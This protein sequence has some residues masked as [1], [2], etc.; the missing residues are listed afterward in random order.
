MRTLL[1]LLAL[2][3]AAPAFAGDSYAAI[4]YDTT[5][6]A[7]TAQDTGK[8]DTRRFDC[9][10]IYL[11]TSGNTTAAV[12]HEIYDASGTALAIDT[13]TLV[14]G[15]TRFV[16]SWGIGCSYAKDGLL[17]LSQALPPY[18]RIQVAALGT[19]ITGRLVIVGRKR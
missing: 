15:K 9:V 14:T 16:G 10:S 11:V 5:S 7:N 17:G 3:V 2:L 8:L 18:I 6:A 12:S 4:L 19:S 13:G 1:L